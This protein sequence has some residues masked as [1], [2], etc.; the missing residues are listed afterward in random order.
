M[1]GYKTVHGFVF[2]NES[3]FLDQI[4]STV[5]FIL[6]DIFAVFGNVSGLVT[7]KMFGF[8]SV[9]TCQLIREHSVCD[10]G[11]WTPDSWLATK[12]ERFCLKFT[13]PLQ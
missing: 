9:N 7:S 1:F 10:S 2:S 11:M 13:H 4:Q 12:L 6:E 8:A 5:L 3:T